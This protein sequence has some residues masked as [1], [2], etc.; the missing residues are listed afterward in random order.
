MRTRREGATNGQRGLSVRLEGVSKRYQT[1]DG[2][3]L[4][5][6]PT[7]LTIEAGEFVSVVG[8]S[9]CGK[10]TLL[11]LVS[12]LLLPSQGRISIGR[13][14]VTKPYTDL[15]FV[16]QSDVLMDWL[17]VLSNVMVPVEIKKLK[18]REDYE[19]RA[20]EILKMV[21]L[22][23]FEDRHPPELSGGMRQRVSISRALIT[24]PPLLLMDE[25][26]GALDALT[27]EQMNDDL[28]RLWQ[29]SQNT[30]LFITHN[31]EEAVYLSDRVVVMSERPGQVLDVLDMSDLPRPRTL[32]VKDMPEFG[33]HI[34][35][36]RHIFVTQGILGGI[37]GEAPTRS[38][39]P[40]SP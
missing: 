27:R 7:T 30:V 1:A 16:F 34:S 5:L 18:P 6:K 33:T 10:T 15:G 13:Q 19:L 11:M 8:P 40:Y 32:A 35:Q 24:Q 4:A 9:G 26:F 31:I 22:E 14:E 3:L 37:Q 28:Q 29:N 36:I 39:I 23:E 25:P 12:G 2:G 21:G 20:R 17:T 38:S